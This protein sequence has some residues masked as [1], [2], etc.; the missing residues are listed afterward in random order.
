MSA[1]ALLCIEPLK[2]LFGR[3]I[4]DACQISPLAG[5]DLGD[6][7]VALGDPL[8]CHTRSR[9]TGLDRHRLHLKPGMTGHWQILGSSRI[10]LGEMVKLDYL[11]VAGWSLWADVKTLVRTVPYVLARRGM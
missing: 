5:L 2:R 1:G 8:A 4:A 6:A 7:P 9:S 3:C 10:P 11:Y